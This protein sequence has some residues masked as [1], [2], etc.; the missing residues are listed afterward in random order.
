M[1]TRAVILAHNRPGLLAECVAAISPQVGVVTI[2][3]NASYPP[4]PELLARNVELVRIPDQPPNIAAMWNTVLDRAPNEYVAFLCDDTAPAPG[5][6]DSVVA[7]MKETGAVA[8]STHQITPVPAPIHKRDH[9]N[10]VAGRMCGYAFVLDTR[11]SI[12]ADEDMHWWWCDTD[13]DW[14]ARCRSGTVIAPGPVVTNELPN[15]HISNK[16]G[17][18]ERAAL[19]GEAFEAKWGRRPW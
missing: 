14:Q 8:G 19:D 10:D 6:F 11:S 12:R 9:D 7:A 3:D 2:L 16:A 18:W 5:W 15:D 4:V 1:R 17:F 13:I